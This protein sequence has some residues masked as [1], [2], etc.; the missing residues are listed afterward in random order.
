MYRSLLVPLDGSRFAEAA[1]PVATA[2]ATRTGATIHLVRVHAA[3]RE[4]EISAF[5]AFDDEVRAGERAYLESV[6]ERLDRESDIRATVNVEQDREPT[7]ICARARACGAELIVM[8]THGRTGLSRAWIGSVADGV[9]RDAAV[10]VLLVRPHEE[11]PSK[12]S[13]RLFSEILVP[14]DGSASSESIVPHALALGALGGA[15]YTLLRVVQPYIAPL[16]AAPEAPSPLV[17]QQVL[18]RELE[19][20]RKDVASVAERMRAEGGAAAVRT[21]VVVDE[22][23]A[24]AILERLRQGSFD[25]AALATHGRG[26]RRVMVGSVADK[27]LRGTALPLLVYRPPAT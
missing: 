6:A 22:F 27:L 15:R 16:M 26:L 10:P 20:A 3:V 19:C 21:D 2:I 18:D 14:L 7:A 24:I 12:A 9:I 13:A 5:A 23:P 17:D 25:L 8:T 4:A 11:A 1:L